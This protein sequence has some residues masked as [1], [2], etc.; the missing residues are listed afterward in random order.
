MTIKKNPILF[1]F[2]LM[3][4]V[5]L[6]GCTAPVGSDI[7]VAPDSAERCEAH[8]QSI[9]LEL[10]AVAIMANNVGCVC[11]RAR[12]SGAGTG[13]DIAQKGT[14]ARSRASTAAGGMV[15]IE[16]ERERQRQ[17]QTNQQRYY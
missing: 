8:C 16:L 4:G 3:G 14:D 17:M 1:L 7:R 9:G 6:S 12:V 13:G 15:A 5:G 10:T 2:V 11:E